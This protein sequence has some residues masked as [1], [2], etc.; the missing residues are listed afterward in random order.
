MPATSA[1]AHKGIGPPVS[2]RISEVLPEVGLSRGWSR[3]AGQLLTLGVGGWVGGRFEKNERKRGLRGCGR[4]GWSWGGW[5]SPQAVAREGA[6]G[7]PG[8]ALH[9]A[10]EGARWR[11]KPRA[12]AHAT[13]CRQPCEADPVRLQRLGEHLT[14]ACSEGWAR[15]G[16]SI[17]LPP[18]LERSPPAPPSTWAHQAPYLGAHA[19]AG[20]RPREWETCPTTPGSG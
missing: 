10:G 16:V 9:S 5:C 1:Q 2:A 11:F 17:Y 12:A 18:T 6:D 13:F 20:D 14:H 15:R 3:T 4:I 7:G 8:I 19:R